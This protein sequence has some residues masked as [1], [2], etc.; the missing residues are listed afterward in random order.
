LV[1]TRGPVFELNSLLWAIKFPDI[2]LGQFYKTP[3]N[4]G[5][6]IKIGRSKA[7]K[8]VKFPVK[9]PVNSKKQGKPTLAKR[10]AEV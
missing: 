7:P 9:F 6:L 10:P 1:R 8:K 5:H 4:M 2:F 3:I